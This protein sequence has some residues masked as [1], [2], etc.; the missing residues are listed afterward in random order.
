[1]RREAKAPGV[2]RAVAAEFPGELAPLHD[3]RRCP[4]GALVAG[5]SGHHTAQRVRDGQAIVAVF[6][7]ALRIKLNAQC[8][9]TRDANLGTMITQQA[10]RHNTKY[11]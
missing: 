5:A 9:G 4:H 10:E 2:D 1:M 7:A 6:S 8:F 11:Q 3:E